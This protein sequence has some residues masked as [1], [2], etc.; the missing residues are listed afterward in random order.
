MT[1]T[2]P[3]TPSYIIWPASRRERV[4]GLTWA[5][6]RKPSGPAQLVRTGFNIFYFVYT[7][8]FNKI[9]DTSKHDPERVL[10]SNRIFRCR[11]T[12]TNNIYWKHWESPQFLFSQWKHPKFHQE[13]AT[14]AQCE[15]RNVRYE[16]FPKIIML[17]NAKCQK[18]W[19]ELPL[20]RQQRRSHPVL[21]LL[22]PRRCR[23][24][25]CSLEF[26]WCHKYSKI[27]FFPV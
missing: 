23:P 27:W 22:P 7:F 4:H 21:M 5:I 10:L 25:L 8:F 14:D 1:R 18:S 3:L 16:Y 19:V 2:D 26:S 11:A 24:R 12:E 13:T 6:R 9:S 17:S 20:T 15:K